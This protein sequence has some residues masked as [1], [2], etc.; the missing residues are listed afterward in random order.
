MPT[1]KVTDATVEPITLAQAKLWTRV[2]TGDED[3]LFE[4][5]CIPAARQDAERRMNRTILPTTWRRHDD[6]FPSGP[7]IRLH[8]PLLI[9]VAHVKYYDPDGVLQTLS[10]SSYTPDTTSE[11]ARLCLAPGA[12]WP[13]TQAGRANAV[14][15]EYQAG[16]PDAAAVPATIKQWIALF[17]ATLFNNRELLAQGVI[18]SDIKFADGLLD[19][20]KVWSL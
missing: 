8:Y 16:W 1:I 19:G 6:A 18:V 7:C 9:S 15:I 11:P 20:Y 4:S 17:A 10:P 3:S 14:E 2:D 13:A 5:L 12:S